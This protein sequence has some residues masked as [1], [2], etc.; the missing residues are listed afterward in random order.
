MKSALPLAWIL[1]DP[2]GIAALE[3]G[4]RSNQIPFAQRIE[5][6]CRIL[7]GDPALSERAGRSLASQS[8][9]LGIPRHR[10]GDL[11]I[12]KIAEVPDPLDG[13]RHHLR[14]MLS[15]EQPI[16]QFRFTA[17]ASRQG[18]TSGVIGSLFGLLAIARWPLRLAS[19]SPHGPRM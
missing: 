11:D 4:A 2:F 10:G 13:R 19:F 5:G 8:S 16:R 15:F 17:R 7:I 3:D 14:R 18:A 1:G 6:V 12:I 9:S